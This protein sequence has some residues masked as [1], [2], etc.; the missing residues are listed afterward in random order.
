[1]VVLAAYVL[2]NFIRKNEGY[3]LPENI[4][5][6]SER[7]ETSEERSSNLQRLPRLRGRN[8]EAVFDVREQPKHFLNSPEGS[9]DWQERAALTV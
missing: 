5:N 4:E 6:Q 3:N 8:T 9:V 1:M 7:T 2:H